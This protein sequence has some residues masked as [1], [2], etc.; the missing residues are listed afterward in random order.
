[1]KWTLASLGG[2]VVIAAVCVG[3]FFLHWWIFAYATNKTSQI[4]QTS[5]ARQTAL[6]Q[7]MLS[8]IDQIS[9]IQAQVAASTGGE[10]QALQAQE[11]QILQQVCDDDQTL[12][13][14]FATPAIT[15]FVSANCGSPS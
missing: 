10:A 13:P 6:Q 9:T 1:V 3:L 7:E 5:Y 12:T 15:S 8:D 14:S 4:Y 11:S 2:I